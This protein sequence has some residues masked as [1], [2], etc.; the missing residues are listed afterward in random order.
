[1]ATNQSPELVVRGGRLV[2]PMN[3][4]DQVTDIAIS[5]GRVVEVGPDLIGEVTLDATGCIVAPGFVDLHSHAQDLPGHRLAAMD[6]VTTAL[7]LESGVAPI[8]SVYARAAAEGRP[9]NYGYSAPWAAARMQVLADVPRDGTIGTMLAHL[10]DPSW[11]RPADSREVRQILDLLETDLAAGAL[12]IGVIVGY[13]QASDPAEYLAVARLAAERGVPTYTHA[14]DLI[15]TTPDVRMDGAEE[16]VRAA[17]ETGAHMHYCHVNST[18]FQHV[19][20]VL[21]LVDKVRAE[22]SVVSTEAYP[23]GAGMTGIGAEFLAP[24][25]LGARGMT[26]QSLI[27]AP[28][29]ETVADAARLRELRATDPGGLVI[30]HMLDETKPADVELLL[31]SLASTDACIASDAMPLTWQGEPDQTAWPL[32]PRAF[33]HPRSAGTFAKSYRLLVGEHRLMDVSEFVR[34]ASCN[35]A[36]GVAA[37]TSGRVQKGTLAVGADADLVV[38]DPDSYRDQATYLA[39]TRPSTGVRHLVV[40]GTPVVRDN[41]LQLDAHPGRAVRAAQV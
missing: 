30:V 8:E 27:F 25:R 21:G 15:D 17:A 12:G 16:V 35:P 26:P 39:C 13:A 5:G 24:E 32:P 33:T 31:R 36:A 14:R 18:S 37:A 29:G 9:L 2:D 10:G 40:D 11:N 23:Y 28:T 3:G 7:D 41:E 19:D 22:G 34:R 6:G 20:R 4:R 1:M 38:F